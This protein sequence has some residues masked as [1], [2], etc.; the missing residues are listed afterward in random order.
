MIALGRS[1]RKHSQGRLRLF[2]NKRTGH[3]DKDSFGDRKVPIVS[4]ELIVPPFGECLAALLLLMNF[5]RVFWWTRYPDPSNPKRLVIYGE[6][7]TTVELNENRH[8]ISIKSISIVDD[9]RKAVFE[10]IEKTIEVYN[11][12]ART[13]NPE[14]PSLGITKRST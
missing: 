3:P 8:P 4:P 6:V 12:L 7:A 1:I 2:R 10:V 5:N 11:L 14:Y 9:P 13:S